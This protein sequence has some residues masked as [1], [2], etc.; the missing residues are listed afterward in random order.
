MSAI[1][2]ANFALNLL[3]KNKENNSFVFSPFSLGTALSILQAGAGGKTKEEITAVLLEG[4]K[5]DDVTSHYQTILENLNSNNGKDITIEVASKFFLDNSIALKAP[6]QKLVQDAFKASVENHNFNDTEGAAAVVNGFVNES[7]HGKISEIVGPDVF[8]NALAVLINAVYFKGLW[9]T[10]FSKNNTKEDDFHANAGDRKEH[11][12]RV[13]NIDVLLNLNDDDVQ[14]CGLKYKNFDYAMWFF[15]PKQEL[16]LQSWLSETN[17][18]KLIDLISN[19]RRT[20]AHVTIPKFKIESELSVKEQL[21]QLGMG[22]VFSDYADLSAVSEE[23]LKVSD[24]IHKAVIEVNEEGAE[25]AAAT[26]VVMMRS[27][28]AMPTTPEEFVA[29]RPFTFALTHL[30]NIVFMGTFQ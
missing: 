12:M 2:S 17:G 13:F 23:P 27:L 22:T 19:A 7:T 6:Y 15:L 26:A 16:S 5:S 14:V 30:K 29:D 18:E 9:N 28:S 11:F 24:V 25:A 3:N 4:Q 8:S 20:K 1:A 21:E 10:P